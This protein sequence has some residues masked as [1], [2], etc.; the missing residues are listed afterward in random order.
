MQ[1]GRRLVTAGGLE[2]LGL[3]ATIRILRKLE[4]FTNEDSSLVVLV[5]RRC[6]AEQ[7][8]CSTV[9][10]FES[11]VQRRMVR[12]RSLYARHER[13]WVVIMSTGA[14]RLNLPF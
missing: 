5:R 14:H 13:R 1:S 11:L 8:L 6:I 4:Q 2:A 3:F 9:A 12:K 10:F 7:I